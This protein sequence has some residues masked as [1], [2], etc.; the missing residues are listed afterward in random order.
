MK[1]LEQVAYEVYCGHLGGI[2]PPWESL[3]PEQQAAWEAAAQAVLNDYDV[4]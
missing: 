2:T 1:P 3:T 4:F